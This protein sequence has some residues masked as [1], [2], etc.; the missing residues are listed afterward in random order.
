MIKMKKA[1]GVFFKGFILNTNM[2]VEVMAQNRFVLQLECIFA[3]L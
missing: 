1:M 2:S 3:L